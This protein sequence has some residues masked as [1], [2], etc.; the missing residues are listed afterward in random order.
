MS[1]IPNCNIL[2]CS[3]QKISTFTLA[4]PKLIAFLKNRSAKKNENTEQQPSAENS[5]A[6]P[7]TVRIQKDITETDE[8]ATTQKKVGAEDSDPDPLDPFVEF[9][10]QKDYVNMKDVE[11][12]KL[13]WM[14]KVPKIELDQV[15]F[16]TQF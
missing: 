14:K 6:T 10:I 2:D 5:S 15:C 9:D 16:N 3:H 7:K 4:D 8:N 1:N 11:K 13:E 12:E